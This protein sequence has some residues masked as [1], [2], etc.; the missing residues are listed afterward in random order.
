MKIFISKSLFYI[1]D[2]EK[3]RSRELNMLRSDVPMVSVPTS[4][5]QLADTANVFNV[6]LASVGM[7]DMNEH[8]NFLTKYAV[9]GNVSLDQFHVI[10]LAANTSSKTKTSNKSEEEKSEPTFVLNKLALLL[11]STQTPSVVDTKKRLCNEAM[12][13]VS[14]EDIHQKVDFALVRLILQMGETLQVLREEEQFATKYKDDQTSRA[15]EWNQSTTRSPMSS[16]ENMR[17]KSWKNMYNVMTLY[18][19]DVTKPSAPVSRKLILYS[20]I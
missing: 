7:K 8:V 11:N 16:P 18:T 15:A 14:I 9:R 4:G 2:G 20:A 6:I 10:L 3:D 1:S 12:F 5:M 17:A 19:T 13:S